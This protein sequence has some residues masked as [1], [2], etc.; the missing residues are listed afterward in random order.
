MP[1]VA[2]AELLSASGNQQYHYM[3]NAAPWPVANRDGVY[4][5]TFDRTEDAG[6]TV[7]L[8][9][10]PDYLPRRDG[11]V[12]ISKCDGFWKIVPNGKGV[13]LTYQ[14]LADPAGA[15]PSWIANRTVVGT[16][17]KTLKNL[18]GHLQSLPP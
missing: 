10:L 5:F 3:E 9:A 18:R 4:R 7:R 15:I 1:D 12:R 14:V 17:W 16:P 8:E 11:K 6:M 13:K 2:R